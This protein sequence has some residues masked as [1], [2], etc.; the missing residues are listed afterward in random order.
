[1]AKHQI[2]T[3]MFFNSNRIKLEINNRKISGKFQILENET[4]NF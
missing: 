1:M 4:R 3:G 2:I